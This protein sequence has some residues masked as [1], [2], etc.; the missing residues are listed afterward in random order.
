MFPIAISPHDH[1]RVYA[2]SQYVHETTDGGETWKTISPDLTRNDPSHADNS[3]GMAYDNLTTFDG[4]IVWA[5]AESP[6]KAGAIDG[7]VQVTLDGGAHW[8]NTTKNGEQVNRGADLQAALERGIA[9]TAGGSPYLV[10]VNI[11][12]YGGGAESTW[13]QKFNLASERTRNV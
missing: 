2:G 1:N 7:Q 4:S 10:E 11:S 9:A 5:I 3:G 8:T 12:R 13:Y 6:V